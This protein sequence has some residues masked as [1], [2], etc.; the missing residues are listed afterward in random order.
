MFVPP[1]RSSDRHI[2]FTLIELLVVIAIIAILI[3]LLLPAVQKVREAAARTQCGN[4]L[5][6]IGVA[7]HNYESVYQTLPPQTRIYVPGTTWHGP[8]LWW[9]LSEF[10]EQGNSFNALPQGPGIFSQMSQWWLGDSLNPAEFDRKRIIVSN[11]RPK[12]YHCP[13]SNLPQTTFEIPISTGVRWEY[14]WSS[15]VA[16]AGSTNHPSTDRTTPPGASHWSAGG[17]FPGAKARRFGDMTDGLS[18]IFMIGEQ[19][20]Y[21]QGNQENRTAMPEGG[22]TL[23]VKNSRVPSGNGTCSSTGIH[24]PYTINDTDCRCIN[25][26]SIRQPPNPPVTANWQMY[27]N[28]NTPLTSKH[29]GG[30]LMLRGDGSTSFIQDSISLMILQSACD[31]NDGFAID[32][33]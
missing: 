10:I 16:I 30:I 20:A 6:Q 25:L 19:S 32:L 1:A 24:N 21:L 4:N 3:G 14:Q 5:K 18:N 31:I 33:P 8:T 28:C 29:V 11:F 15:Y 2:G 7:I 9:T 27:P 23:G 12:I 17:T 13:S 26:T 22:H